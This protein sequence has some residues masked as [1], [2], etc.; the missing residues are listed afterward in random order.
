MASINKQISDFIREHFAIGDDPDFTDEVHLFDLVFVDSLGA[1]ELVA[2]VEEAFNIQIT[3]K[4][5]NAF[6]H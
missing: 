4:D 3:Q 2:F 1:M 6:R 5:D